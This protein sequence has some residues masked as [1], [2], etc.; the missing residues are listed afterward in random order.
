M[1]RSY[2]ILLFAGVFFGV[3]IV[4]GIY[5]KMKSPPAAPTEPSATTQPLVERLREERQRRF[6][7]RNAATTHPVP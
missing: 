3:L 2:L 1:D 5:A 6:N 4:Y 7:E